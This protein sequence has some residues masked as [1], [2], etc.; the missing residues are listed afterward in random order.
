MQKQ[1]MKTMKIIGT[2]NRRPLRRGLCTLL[3]GI[4]AL[5]A[6]PRNA[7]AQLYVGELNLGRVGEYDATGAAIKPAF[8]T[9]LNWPVVLALSGND[10]YVSNQFGGTVGEYDATTGAAI[11]ISGICP[12]AVAIQADLH[13][14]LL[15]F[16][17][18]Y[19]TSR[20]ARG[21]TLLQQQY[22]RVVMMRRSSC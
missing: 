15:K 13:R 9:G 11:P 20:N 17:R 2:S 6:M 22:Y 3:L 19:F 4:A 8:I 16:I 14:K 1:T 5:S 18:N 12:S 7:R 10:L 21:A